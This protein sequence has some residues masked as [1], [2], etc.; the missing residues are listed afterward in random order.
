MVVQSLRDDESNKF[1]AISGTPFGN[2]GS[3]TAIGV[4]LCGLQSGTADT[5]LPLICTSEGYLQNTV[6]A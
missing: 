1:I 2:T 5:Y 3:Q 4:I 6:T